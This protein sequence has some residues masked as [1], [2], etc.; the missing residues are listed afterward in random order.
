[1]FSRITNLIH[2]NQ[3]NRPIDPS[4]SKQINDLVIYFIAFLSNLSFFLYGYLYRPY[5]SLNQYIFITIAII[6]YLIR[7]PR[8]SSPVAIIFA[9]FLIL[10]IISAKIT[11]IEMF[12]IKGGLILGTSLFAADIGWQIMPS[13]FGKG[14]LLWVQWQS[15]AMG[16]LLSS[17][18]HRNKNQ[19]QS[20][21]D[22]DPM[23]LKVVFSC[24]G[25]MCIYLVALGV[26]L[27]TSKRTKS[28]QQCQSYK[29]EVLQV[30][31]VGVIMIS[32]FTYEQQAQLS[33]N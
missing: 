27:L 21:N 7:K 19:K 29:N 25:L 6:Y 13:H 2:H 15:F 33:I 9:F 16:L 17:Q 26:K 12:S 11:G 8:S 3:R 24:I 28:K 14:A 18:V 32:S 10:V 31:L 30:L 1:M 22:E 4:R 20:I 5:L 23:V